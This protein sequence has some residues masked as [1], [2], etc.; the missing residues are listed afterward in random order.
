MKYNLLVAV[1]A[2]LLVM[3]CHDR[4]KEP[5]DTGIDTATVYD[6]KPIHDTIEL[7]SGGRF[8][9]VL[10]TKTGD[11]TFQV[12]G[13]AQVF[14]AAFS[15]VI[16]DGHHELKVGHVMTDAG[17]PA[18]GKFSF[19][20]SAPMQQPDITLQLILFEASPKDGSRE[21]ELPIVLYR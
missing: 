2:L 18:W 13:E 8:R 5:R 19:M 10:V 15:W 12:S 6:D 7:F 17:A 1:Y 4:S 14:E 11:S 16:E 9:N 3:A 21:N 20:V